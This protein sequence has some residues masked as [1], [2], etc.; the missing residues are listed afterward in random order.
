MDFSLKENETVLVFKQSISLKNIEEKKTSF[1]IVK[2]QQNHI[3]LKQYN[4]S[5][6]HS[7]KV[8]FIIFLGNLGISERR[9]Q[10]NVVVITT[11]FRDIYIYRG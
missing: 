7:V 9:F 10:C 1:I 3:Y 11:F 6:K 2:L 4:K 8:K 5:I